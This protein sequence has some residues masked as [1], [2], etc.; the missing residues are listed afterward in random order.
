[1]LRKFL[2]AVLS[3]MIIASVAVAQDAAK[4]EVDGAHSSVSFKISHMVI[5]KVKGN[6]DEFSADIMFPE[7][8]P[9]KGSVNFTIQVA[10]V[11][12]DNTKRDDHLK[13]AD[14]FDVENYPTMTFVSKSVTKV[15]DNKYKITGDL[16]IRGTTE[17]VTF[18]AELNGIVQ[19]PWGGTRAG[20]SVTTTIDRTDFGLTYG[21]VMETGGL[22]VGHDVE[23]EMELELVKAK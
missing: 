16:T 7:N 18:D 4:W 12:T 6:F 23:I 14:F 8:D 2:T 5:S 21:K 13:A 9:S 1:M 19:D 15:S 17:E 20:F 3:L 22:M 10:S 11:D